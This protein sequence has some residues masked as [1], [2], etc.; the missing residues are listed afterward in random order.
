M[1][2]GQYNRSKWIRADGTLENAKYLGYL[3]A[4][5]LYPDLQPVKFE[6]FLDD[7]V[8]G[9][10]TRPYEEPILKML[11]GMKGGG[12]ERFVLRLGD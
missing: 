11:V 9:R 4:R 5:E 10:V 7:L 12:E 2:A 6:S 1:N 8:Q 3:D